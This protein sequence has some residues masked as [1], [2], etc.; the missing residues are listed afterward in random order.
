VAAAGYFLRGANFIHTNFKGARMS[1]FS[2]SLAL[3]CMELFVFLEGALRG[4]ANISDW[5][6]GL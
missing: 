1:L 3:L 5:G 6:W 4:G 2:Y